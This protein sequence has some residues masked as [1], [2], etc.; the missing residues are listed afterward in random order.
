MASRAN[1][2]LDAYQ[3]L[4]IS[5]GCIQN[6]ADLGKLLEKARRLRKEFYVKSQKENAKRV[7]WAF[8]QIKAGLRR[9]S[10]VQKSG[11]KPG[12]D[13]T[14]NANRSND[15]VSKDVTSGRSLKRGGS[16]EAQDRR[17]AIREKAAARRQNSGNTSKDENDP[18]EVRREAIREKLAQRRMWKQILVL[19]EEECKRRVIE[20]ADSDSTPP[21][22]QGRLCLTCPISAERVKTPARGHKCTHL[23]CFDLDAFIASR[24]SHCPVCNAAL[25]PPA[26]L[27]VDSYVTRIIAA[28]SGKG[29]EV[30][31]DERGTWHIGAVRKKNLTKVGV[32]SVRDKKTAAPDLAAERGR[33][34]TCGETP[35]SSEVQGH[36]SRSG[37][38]NSGLAKQRSDGSGLGGTA[39]RPAAVDDGHRP[40]ISV[41]GQDNIAC[42][43]AKSAAQEHRAEGDD[44][45]Q[46][47]PQKKPRVLPKDFVDPLEDTSYVAVELSRPMGIIFQAN[48]SAAGGGVSVG[49]LEACGAAARHGGLKVGDQLVAVGNTPVKGKDFDACV[50]RI[51]AENEEKTLL[52][53]FRGDAT[54]LYNCEGV[55][56][57]RIEGLLAKVSDGTIEIV[58]PAPEIE[59][60]PSEA[61]EEGPPAKKKKRRRQNRLSIPTSDSE[62]SFSSCGSNVSYGLSVSFSEG[63]DT[64][65]PESATPP[66]PPCFRERVLGKGLDADVQACAEAMETVGFDVVPRH[67]LSS[68]PLVLSVSKLCADGNEA[69]WAAL[70]EKA[71]WRK[72]ACKRLAQAANTRAER[73]AEEAL[74]RQKEL[75]RKL[76]E[77]RRNDEVTCQKEQAAKVVEPQ[78]AERAILSLDP[79]K[80][81]RFDRACAALLTL[82][83]P[84]SSWVAFRLRT[85]LPRLINV[86]PCV[87]TLGGGDQAKLQ[88]NI[89]DRRVVGGDLRFLVQAAVAPSGEAMSKEVWAAL[90]S[91]DIQ[92]WRL[93]GRIHV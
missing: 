51:V 18:E 53:F 86:T 26:D 46:P 59:P 63:E 28:M 50:D 31:I 33:D 65:E 52:T 91:K 81:I 19:E 69:E 12:V 14:A 68:S 40:A 71:A 61:E 60:D 79:D 74:E 54:Y 72:T 5:R 15:E 77:T 25:E 38:N 20:F 23:Q 73:L 22:L 57:E 49:S 84:T 93:S 66:P 37:S 35:Q 42:A 11:E 89:M 8:E 17:E 85:S 3:V 7:E 58:P 87:G 88:I 67:L 83:N 34:D 1:N 78:P 90:A 27:Y 76:D 56:D 82:T 9:G 70:E 41:K 24:C 32:E 64:D 62:D 6:S 30:F 13:A 10:R 47:P 21:P 48:A 55:T 36:Q 4:G 44:K 45:V 80:V 43:A 39:E 16:S 29:R 92:E 2:G 75:E